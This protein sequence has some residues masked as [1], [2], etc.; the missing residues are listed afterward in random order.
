MDRWTKEKIIA[1]RVQMY[2]EIDEVLRRTE[3]KIFQ[4]KDKIE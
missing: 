4:L 3:V 2:K 1:L